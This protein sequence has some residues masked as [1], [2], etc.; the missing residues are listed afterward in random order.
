MQKDI[1]Q[2]VFTARLTRDPELRTTP[3][4][5]SVS[6]LRVAIGRPNGKDGS[7]RKAAFYDLEVWGKLAESCVRYLAKGRRVAVVARLEHQQWT[8]EQDQPRQ[9]NYLVGD[10]VRFLDPPTESAEEP[11]ADA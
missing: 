8:D 10:E 3:Q 5:A 7:D 4:G 9:R 2:V 6:T 1:N 11:E